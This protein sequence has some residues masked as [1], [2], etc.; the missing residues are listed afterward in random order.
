MKLLIIN[1]LILF[2]FWGCHKNEVIPYEDIS[3]K[4]MALE[5]GH[6]WIYDVD[7]VYYYGNITQKP[8]TFT[9]QVRNKIISQFTSLSGE[10]TYLISTDTRPDSS[11]NWVFVKN[12]SES[13]S[14]SEAKRTLGEKTIVIMSVPIVLNNIWN[15]NQY[16]GSSELEFSYEKVHQPLSLRTLSFDSTSTVFWDE[17]I[18]QIESYFV[19]ETFAA[20]TGLVFREEERLDASSSTA[21]TKGFSKKMM[22][23]SF[24][25]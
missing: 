21:G 7:S 1:T 19:K 6:T 9:F 25:K 18:N 22:L 15:G 12:Y 23:T 24:E 20:H 2:S 17:R 3:S 10:T 14:P 13:K 11:S 16:N 8:D 4:Y 5:I